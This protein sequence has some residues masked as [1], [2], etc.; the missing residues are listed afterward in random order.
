MLTIP[1]KAGLGQNDREHYRVRAKRVKKEREATAWILA[2]AK[3]PALPCSVLLTRIAPSSGL[4][5]DNL[6]G[7]LKSVRD[8]VARWLG[9]DD[10]DRM[11]VR[12]RYAQRRGPWAVLVE[13]G[14][15]V[16][17]AQ[18]AIEMEEQPCAPSF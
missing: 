3:R 4:D 2:T 10:R 18:L 17:G 11:T 15:P 7:S 6:A 14:P 16:A 1:I 9:V 13:F 8:E 12:Y 5:D